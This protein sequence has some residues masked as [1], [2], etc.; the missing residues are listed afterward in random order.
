MDVHP[1]ISWLMRLV[2]HV[3]DDQARTSRAGRTRN[4]GTRSPMV[5][6]NALLEQSPGTFYS[7]TP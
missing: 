1:H 3:V 6:S 5:L 4:E 2:L 7:V